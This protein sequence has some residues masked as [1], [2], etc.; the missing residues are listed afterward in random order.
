MD[1]YAMVQSHL[2]QKVIYILIH[3]SGDPQSP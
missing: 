1:K 2:K 3:C